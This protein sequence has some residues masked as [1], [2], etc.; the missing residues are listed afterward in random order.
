MI[1]TARLLTFLRAL[2]FIADSLFIAA[3]AG[4]LSGGLVYRLG[5]HRAAPFVIGFAAFLSFVGL[6][7]LWSS[8]E[9]SGSSDGA[10]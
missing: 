4:V 1:S 5:F 10:T 7:R 8:R 3:I 2:F 6:M 9:K